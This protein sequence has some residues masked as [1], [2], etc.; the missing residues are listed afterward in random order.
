MKK[1]IIATSAILAALPVGAQESPLWLRNT[2]I[3]PDGSKVA[4]TFKG[5]IYTVPA[6]GGQ[7]RQIT[8]NPSYDTAPVWSP[9]G[10][11][12]AFGSDRDGSMDI[13]VIPS[14]GGTA[15][16]LT[17]A[18]AAEM[19]KAWL[20]DST[21]LFSANM[22]P[23]KEAI[24]GP[25]A[26]QIYAIGT[27]GGRP[28]LFSTIPMEAIS[29]AEDGRILYQDRKGY[30][31][32]LRKHERSSSTADIIM[33]DK[34]GKH[35]RLTTFN[36][37]DQNPV[38][39]PDGRFAFLSEEDGTIN[40]YVR[41]PADATATQLTKFTTHPVRSLS[42]SADGKLMAFSW[43][44]EV[45]T[46]I[47]GST[48][49]K[50]DIQITGDDY[51]RDSVN[52]TRTSGATTMAVSPDGKEVAFVLRGDVYVT[53]TDYKTT[54]R[55][56]DT[57]GQERRLGFSK[58]GRTLVYDSERDGL[59]Q[60]FTATIKNPDEKHFAYATEIVETPLYSSDKAAQQPAFSPDGKKVAFLEDRTEIR[61]IDVD[62][63]KVNTALDGRYNYS[64]SDG[65]VE[66]VWSPDSR[67][68][69]A[70]YIGIGGWNNSDIALVTADGSEVVNLTESGYSSSNPRWA[71]D[72]EAVMWESDRYGMR[73]HGS[74]GTQSDVLLMALTPEA[75]DKMHLSAEEAALAKEAESDKKD[76]G[77]NEKDSKK[78][79][80]NSKKDKDAKVDKPAPVKNFD[81]DNR[82]MRIMRL[83]PRSGSLGDYVLAADGSKLYYT[84]ANAD[85]SFN[86]METDLREDETKVLARN[87][88]GGFDPD[89]KVENIYVLGNVMSKVNLSSGT[90]TPIEFEADYS[91]RPSLEREY[92]YDHML[93]QVRDKF[94]DPDLHGV[95]WT[96]Y[97]EAYRRFL[98]YIDNNYDFAILL[99]EILGELNASHTGGRFRPAPEYNT[100]SLGAFF[101]E[102]YT[103]KGIRIAEVM[104]GS[105]LAGAKAN[106]K[107]GEIIT[108]IDGVTIDPGMDYSPLLRNK[109]G[110]R[111]RLTVE[112][113]SGKERN[114]TVRALGSEYGLL[115]RR[116]V[117]RNQEM[118][119]S[120]S[121]GRIGYVHVQG[122]DSPSFRTVFSEMLGK[123]RNR[124]AIIVDTRWNGGGWLHNDLAQLLGGKE[125]V[126][127]RP[128]G[129]YI[130]SEPFTQW[131][132]PSVML[133]NEANYSDA[134][135]SPFVYQ[136]L[137]LGDVVGAP[138]PGTMTAVWWETQ[139]D[140]TLVFGIPQV[141]S[142]DMNGNILENRQLQPDVEVYNTPQDVA[143]GH[144]A[145]IARAVETLLKKLDK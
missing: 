104:P 56:T 10:T 7:A 80:K 41:E 51:N 4:F 59:W 67:H 20:N 62:S 89:E 119:D 91:R 46:L 133:V 97:G 139:I 57:P 43:N 29:I 53:S 69:L 61:V 92:I 103:G 42:A 76:E 131:T 110:K 141:T 11:M 58:D 23:S 136:T 14:E 28:V 50:L 71:L 35:S 75:Y 32:V 123:Y 13:F 25:F 142:V 138:V 114:V 130:G 111:V 18:S 5:D 135:G 124:E 37:P 78:D 125:Y 117:R 44:G 47:P 1:L 115:Y 118:V 52:G 96:G 129:R 94:Y 120:L 132:K 102:D 65:D 128:R 144:D 33:V 84:T 99:S 101:D 39:L 66:F 70:S 98:P 93:S 49:R 55:I 19:P 85:G 90:S 72:G 64:Y 40:I 16:R 74:W 45:Y 79:K 87:V 63:K 82:S 2:A 86:L 122:M 54:R 22:K 21:I 73:S 3:S 113:S 107:D 112:D 31:D 143:A 77:D 8:T 6:T 12:I 108:A 81:L 134:H 83:T 24:Q 116:W 17:T 9:D 109:A 34:E 106:V 145:Q 126:Q 30:E 137:G 38:W 127:F 140:P 88:R 26:S 60:L 36:G 95:D 105:P 68:L 27:G 121:N 15:R 100:A 48:P